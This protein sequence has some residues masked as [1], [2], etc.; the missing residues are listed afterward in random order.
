ML[1]DVVRLVG[2]RQDLRLVDVVHL[3]RLQDLGLGEVPDPGLRHDGNRH[4][5]LNLLDHPGARHAGNAA[6]GADV[7]GNALQRHHRDGAGVLRDSGLLGSGDVHDD[8]ALEHLR[9]P[10]LDAECRSL[11]HWLGI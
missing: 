8:A 9:E 7:G 2:G 1:V 10:T 5:F 3:E 11:R 4:G 6:R